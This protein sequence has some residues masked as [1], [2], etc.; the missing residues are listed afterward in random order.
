MRKRKFPRC[1]PS[2][3]VSLNLWRRQFVNDVTCAIAF[4]SV[5]ELDSPYIVDQL[6]PFK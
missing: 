1:L 6:Y 3:N 4:T 2:I 5:N